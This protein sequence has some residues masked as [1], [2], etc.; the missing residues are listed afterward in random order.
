V[1]ALGFR[2]V[3]TPVL[4]NVLVILLVAM[5]FN[6]PFPRPRYPAA[7]QAATLSTRARTI[8]RDTGT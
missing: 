6:I 1:H 2:F 5:L 7:T 8:P 3:L 4:L